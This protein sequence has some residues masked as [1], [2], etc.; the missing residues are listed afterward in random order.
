VPRPFH[1][2]DVFGLAPFTGNPLAVVAHADDLSTE[3]MQSI[4]AWLNFS[5]TTF[6]LPTTDPAADYR[7]RIFT[8]A[9]ELPFAG[10]P[11]LG[12]AHAWLERGGLPQRQ[13]IIVQECGAGLVRIRRDADRLAFAAPPLIRGGAPT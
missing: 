13:E 1:L 6:L 4:A 5:E 12:S 11:T 8:V 7:V 9:H 2:V 10:H 3:E